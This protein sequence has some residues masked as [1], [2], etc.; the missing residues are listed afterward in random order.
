MNAETLA[1]KKTM[2]AKLLLSVLVCVVIGACISE[3]EKVSAQQVERESTKLRSVSKVS[4]HGVLRHF[5]QDVKSEQAWLGHEYMVGDTPIRPTN[6]VP[7]EKLQNLVGKTV[8]IEG[9]WNPGKEVEPTNE[10]LHSRPIVP[11]G[12]TLI[13]GSGI[14]ALKVMRADE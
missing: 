6:A 13:R 10:E 2:T 4:V 14:E 1:Q 7:A 5:P 8:T 9:V 3:H 11:G 12:A